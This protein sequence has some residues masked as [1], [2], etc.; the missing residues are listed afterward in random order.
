MSAHTAS[1]NKMSHTCTVAINYANYYTLG[2]V[3]W[4]NFFQ[5]VIYDNMPDYE[6]DQKTYWYFS[7]LFS[8]V[9]GTHSQTYALLPVFILYFIYIYIKYS[10]IYSYEKKSMANFRLNRSF[11]ERSVFAFKI[12]L[13]ILHCP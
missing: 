5:V 9:T 7:H 2:V 12:D 6:Y 3:S 10:S 8:E 13:T 4:Y 1:I 11:P